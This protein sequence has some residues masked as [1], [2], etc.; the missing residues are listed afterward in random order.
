MKRLILI[1]IVFIFMLGAC[2]TINPPAVEDTP[3]PEPTATLPSPVVSRDELPDAEALAA[4]YFQNWRAE[5]YAEMYNY[6]TI[7]AKQSYSLEDFIAR[8]KKTAVDLTMKSVDFQILSNLLSTNAAQVSYRVSYET[9]LM[10]TLE[11]D[12]LMN[13]QLEGKVWKINWDPAMMLPELADG[14]YLELVLT[15]PTRGNIYSSDASNNYPLVAYTDAAT[16]SIVPGNIDPDQEDELVAFLAELTNQ[17]EDAVRAKYAYAQPEWMVNI[18]DI[19]AETA[20]QNGSRIDSFAGLIIR[21]FKSRFYY[22]NGI[23]PHV[24]GYMLGISAENQERYQRLGY[25]IDET[26]GASG[27]ELWGEKYLAGKRGADLYVKDKEGKIVTKLASTEAEPAYSITTTIDSRLQYWLQRSMGNQVGAVVVLERDTSRVLA[28]ASSPG[29]DPNIFNPLNHTAYEVSDLTQNV[30]QP[31]YN[32]ASQGVYAPGSI[33]KII[34]M[35]AALQTGVFTPDRVYRCDSQWSEY[36][37]WVG[38]NWTYTQGFASDGDLTLI[39]GLMRSCNPWFWHIGLTLWNDGYKTSIPDEAYT[40]GL[41]ALTGIEIEEF[42]GTVNYPDNAFDYFQMAIGQSTLQ[43]SALQAANFT[44]AIGNGGYL[45]RPTLIDRISFMGEK[46]IYAFTEP[47]L[48]R[49]VDTTPENLEA[50]QQ[51][52]VQVVRNPSGTAA[53]QFERFDGNLAGKTGTAETALG[54]PHAWFVG[55]TFN[56]DPEKPDIAVAVVLEYAGEGS[57]MAAPLFRRA[58]SLYFSNADEPGG[59]MPWEERPYQLLVEEEE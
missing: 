24:T 26:V 17:T 51:A 43:V 52:M 11:R 14:N 3:T 36:D 42:A 2:D 45:H 21:N 53:F 4:D 57:E 50:I 8:H 54:R 6:L 19:S 25:K 46:P 41:G 58:V 28:M 40:Y 13:L 32:R 39:E 56:E 22:D 33:F 49:Q 15:I 12:T 29:F 10:G 47:E 7:P 35:A 38:D 23:A 37:G 18:G 20:S 44:A 55:Y 27:L 34:S 30:R 9:N 5:D 48:I 16:L 31:L 1:L 59:I